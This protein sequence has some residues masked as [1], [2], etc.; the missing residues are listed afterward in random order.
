MTLGFSLNILREFSEVCSDAMFAT[1]AEVDPADSKII[2]ANS[3]FT[4]MTGFERHEVIGLSPQLLQGPQTERQEWDRI[5]SALTRQGVFHGRMTS[6]VKGGRE[7]LFDWHIRSVSDDSGA[8]MNWYSLRGTIK[9]SYHIST[10]PS[11]SVLFVGLDVLVRLGL[12]ESLQKLSQTV[13][14][15]SIDNKIDAIALAGSA[16]LFDLVVVGGPNSLGGALSDLAQILDALK[17]IPVAVVLQSNDFDIMQEC[18]AAGAKGCLDGGME[19]W[20]LADVLRLIIDGGVYAP[21]EIVRSAF[22]LDRRS[23]RRPG[24]QALLENMTERERNICAAL[25][26]GMTNA[27]I[28]RDIGVSESTVKGHLTRLFK[29]LGVTSRTQAL[30]KIGAGEP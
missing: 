30:L 29:K 17:P 24:A 3:A 15:T 19:E 4:A 20:L 16:G 10:M 28:S 11:L 14:I 9:N 2:Y 8:I 26:R 1:T 13:R 18:L 27:E 22:P 25:S 5:R 23:D 7:F 21:Y 12:R 6:Y